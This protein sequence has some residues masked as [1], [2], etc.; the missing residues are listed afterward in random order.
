MTRTLIHSRLLSNLAN[1][2]PDTGTVQEKDPTQN[3]YGEESPGWTDL[4]GHVDLSCAIASM[5]NGSETKRP[6]GTIAIHV[7][8][9]ALAGIYE[10]V[11]PKMQFVADSVAYNI[12]SVQHDSRSKTT[13]LT[14]ERV[15]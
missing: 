8:R 9:A 12:L 6:D 5:P 4:A 14:L 10:D 15:T 7:R 2:Y 3:S 1:F 11:L 13:Y